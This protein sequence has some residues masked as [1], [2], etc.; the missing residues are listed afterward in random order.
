MGSLP[1][2]LILFVLTVFGI[3]IL[4][5]LIS[6]ISTIIDA[7]IRD[8]S[9]GAGVFPFDD[10]IIILG[11][12]N[13]VA[14]IVGELVEANASQAI[15]RIL[16]AS[17]IDH[18]SL[19]DVIGKHKKETKTTNIFWRS[20]KLDSNDTFDNLNLINARKVVVLGDD[21]ETKQLD[22]LKTCIALRNYILS[23]SDPHKE[24]L[25][26]ADDENE[27]RSIK[28]ATDGLAIPVILSRIPGRL[29]FE[30][31]FQP[32]LPSVYEELLSFRGNEL[33]ISDTI[34]NL[35]L[36]DETFQQVSNYFNSSIP[37]GFI[38]E[39]NVPIINPPKNRRMG[40]S[41]RVVVLA[42]DD[43]KIL[44][45]QTETNELKQKTASHG[46]VFRERLAEEK[47][48]DIV[49]AGHS[50]TSIEI[51]DRLIAQSS[52]KI[53]YIPNHIH[54]HEAETVRRIKEAGGVVT[55]GPSYDLISLQN[56][57]AFAADT[58]IV[59]NEDL[60]SPNNSDLTV[61]KTLLTI[62]EGAMGA[63][64]PHI[65]AEL[66]S[67]GSRDLLAELFD[68]D[69]IVSGKLSSKIFAQFI[70]NPELTSI[71]DELILSG[72]HPISFEPL[73]LESISEGLT[74]FDLRIAVSDKQKIVLGLRI[75]KN[76]EMMTLLN[77]GDAFELSQE[78]DRMEA[79]ILE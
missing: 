69:F 3:F 53:T 61:I 16:I 21:N 25:V 35:D 15:C 45:Q 44:A 60:K 74:F 11:Y 33:Y 37:I 6:F 55:D 20:R 56:A 57:G 28:N 73:Q 32:N 68:S 77:P 30:T 19:S 39:N 47:T 79:I 1:Y 23:S 71:I 31:V 22:R 62:R 78:A 43:V 48:R 75:F 72:A 42:E 4:S 10:H 27:A 50:N 29:I 46:I 63:I 34:A 2:L 41:D 70:E 17:N 8:F 40:A 36:V 59:A 13:R 51:V 12:S 54:H 18:S 26:E 66:K 64:K 38:D 14:D 52:C 76:K 9:V 49:L 67:S 7:R 5:I 58:I 65:I 24:F